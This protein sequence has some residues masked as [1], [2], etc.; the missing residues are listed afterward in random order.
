MGMTRNLDPHDFDSDVHPVAERLRAARIDATPVE[1]DRA[2]VSARARAARRSRSGP[3]FLRSK[4]AIVAMLAAGLAT[5][6]AGV[7]FA[8]EGPSG[9]DDASSAQYAAPSPGNAPGQGVGGEER[10]SNPSAGGGNGGDTTQTERQVS[11]T[12][13]GDG[14]NLPFTGLAA[15]PLIVGGFALLAGG[16]ALQRKASRDGQRPASA[17]G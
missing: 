3:S 8:F 9:M 7:T 17:D 12:G 15:I 14:G 16:V 2:L 4:V 1:L 6:G 10:S 13:T 5:S 11:A